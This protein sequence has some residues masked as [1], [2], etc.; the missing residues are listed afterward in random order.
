MPY[1]GPSWPTVASPT[2]ESLK[3][4]DMLS[5][6]EGW[7]TSFNEL[8]YYDGSSWTVHSTLDDSVTLLDIDI[9]SSDDGWE[10][11]WDGVIFHYADTRSTPY[12][13]PTT[14]RFISV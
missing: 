4:I 9:V 6:T 7:A 5:S 10:V 14:D 12:T 1:D 3:G 13:S 8:L 11:G 2:T